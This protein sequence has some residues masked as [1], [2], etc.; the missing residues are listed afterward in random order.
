MKHRVLINYHL[1][2]ADQSVNWFEKYLEENLGKKGKAWWSQDVTD[3]WEWNTRCFYFTNK[4]KMRQCCMIL[5]L[6]KQTCKCGHC[7]TINILG[8]DCGEE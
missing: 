7:G 6:S 4:R 1:D 3:Y 2:D 5:R 8:E